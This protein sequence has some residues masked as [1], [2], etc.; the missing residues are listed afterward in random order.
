[1][2]KGLATADWHLPT[3][4]CSGP[5]DDIGVTDDQFDILHLVAKYCAN[6]KLDLYAAGDLFNSPRPDAAVMAK[7]AECLDPIRQSGT[8]RVYYVIGN[9]D[10]GQDWLSAFPD[11]CVNVSKTPTSTVGGLE[12]TAVW[13]PARWN[14]KHKPQPVGLYHQRWQ[15]WFGGGTA[16][17]SELPQHSVS[18]CGD[19]HVFGVVSVVSGSKAISPGPFTPMKYPEIQTYNNGAYYEL[20]SFSETEEDRLC[21]T[22]VSLPVR[23]WKIVTVGNNPDK[24]LS[25][26]SANI[27][28]ASN[29]P[30]SMSDPVVVLKGPF[31]DKFEDAARAAAKR[32]NVIV[33]LRS[34][35]AVKKIETSGNKSTIATSKGK[36]ALI[37]AIKAREDLNE[38]EMELALKLVDTNRPGDVLKEATTKYLSD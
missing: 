28:V 14:F 20:E 22:L 1:M 5:W 3:R 25:E 30:V 36:D 32:A 27:K 13:P 17:T 37:D 31:P 9:H 2:I 24:A 33:A 26:I 34:G 15:D 19:I 23:A 38:D 4:L 16:R 29:T 12:Y 6:R 10:G 21:T 8:L 7:V 11:F 18:V 35:A